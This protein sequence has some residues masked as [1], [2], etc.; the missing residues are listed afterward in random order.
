MKVLVLTAKEKIV[1]SVRDKLQSPKSMS[2]CKKD[3]TIIM[4]RFMNYY[5]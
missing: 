1:V 4:I 5:F 2:L 3:I